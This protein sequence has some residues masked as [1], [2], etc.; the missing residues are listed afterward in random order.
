MLQRLRAGHR[1]GRGP[2]GGVR[3]RAGDRVNHGRLGPKGLFGWQANLAADRLTRPLV[4]EGGE[5]VEAD[6]DAA[7]D[8]IVQRSRQQLD[9]LGPGS[10]GFYTSGQLFLEEYYTLGVIGKAGLGTPHMDGNTWLCTATAGQALKETFGTDGQPASYT[11]V[12]HADTIF[13]CGHNPAATQTV[14][15]SRVLD[16][17]RGPNPAAGRG[18]PRPT[19]AAQEADVHLAIRPGTNLALLNGLL[20][21]VIERGWTDRVFVDAH[22]V[23]FDQLAETVGSYDP[24]RV[25]GI[26][27]VPADQVREAARIL[28]TGERLLSTVL[29]GVYQSMSAT[30]AACQV[31]NLNLVR[32][33]VGRP[34]CGVL[35]MNGQPTAQNTRETGADG[36]LR[37]SATGTTRRTSASWP[38][39]GTSTRS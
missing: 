33:M 20:H 28:G 9:T 21:E 6:W 1:R 19:P 36:D 23:G 35:Q 17:R 27:G 25:A 16:R 31:N 5:L 4:R 8:R 22:T 26:C 32:G 13:L 14:L 38:S 10:I 18:R 15:W 3:G 37:A 2:D 24:E 29:Q 7:M 39:C 34:G 12:D 11:D 30:A